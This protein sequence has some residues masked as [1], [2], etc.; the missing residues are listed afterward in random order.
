MLRLGA[1]IALSLL[2]APGAAAATPKA[3][4]AHLPP[5]APGARAL[6]ALGSHSHALVQV[7]FRRGR[8]AVPALRLAGGTLVSERLAV[9]R[10]PSA[11]AQRL[12]PALAAA[13]LV[14]TV[15]PDRRLAV[16]GHLSAGDP[17]VPAQW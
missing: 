12:V 5:K 11:A 3:G 13:G 6:Q 17:L 7:D 9:W 4:E 2:V 15:E 14:R 16:R 10:V 8:L 1:A